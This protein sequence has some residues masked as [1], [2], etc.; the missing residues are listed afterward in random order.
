LRVAT[1]L[2]VAAHGTRAF[3][4]LWEVYG[5]CGGAGYQAQ[6]L[7]AAAVGLLRDPP[8]APAFR[9]TLDAAAA[10]DRAL[11]S[12]GGAIV[13]FLCCETAG[14]S[15]HR[16][17]DDARS[18]AHGG[19]LAHGQW[20]ELQAVEHRPRPLRSR[21]SAVRHRATDGGAVLRHAHRFLV[22]GRV[23][24][25][26]V[27]LPGGT[28]LIDGS[29]SMRLDGKAILALLDVAPGAQVAK[30]DGADGGW[31]RIRILARG[32][33]RVQDPL[34]VEKCCGKGNVIDGPALRWLATQPRP[35]VWVSDGG[36]TGV[37]DVTSADL[38]REA[39]DLCDLHAITRVED[40]AAA[41]EALE[42]R[43]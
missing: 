28:L 26:R 10:L 3:D 9:L 14:R 25:R 42:R 22:D 13:P 24:A 29:G 17:H 36:V 23:F 6:R 31:G 38:R 15:R 43:G 4:R 5:A 11:G 20:G 8:K 30:Y 27:R 32:G 21:S 40:S 37:G 2:L 7:A 19:G 1:L 33:W 39:Q 34:L 12:T 35:R 18:R 16:R 41:R